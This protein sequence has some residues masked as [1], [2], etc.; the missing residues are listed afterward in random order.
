MISYK[1]TDGKDTEFR[2]APTVY[3]TSSIKDARKFIEGTDYIINYVGVQ[4]VPYEDVIAV[5]L[6][7]EN[8]K[9]KDA[10]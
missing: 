5:Q 3:T 2:T 4:G 10:D 7:E 6:D 9:T 8:E 1:I